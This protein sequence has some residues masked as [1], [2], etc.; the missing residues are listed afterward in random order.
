MKEQ[1]ITILLLLTVTNTIFAQNATNSSNRSNLEI[2][3]STGETVNDLFVLK[4][5]PSTDTIATKVLNAVNITFIGESAELFNFVQN[6]LYNQGSIKEIEPPRLAITN[7][8]G[9]F[10]VMGFVLDENGKKIEKLHSGYVDLH[11]GMFSKEYSH[12]ESITQLFP[13]EMG[14]VIQMY[15]CSDL[16][17]LEPESKS[18]NIH[19]FNITTNYNTAFSEGFAEHF[20]NIARKMEPSEKVKAGIYKDIESKRKDLPRYIKGFDR[21]FKLPLRVGFYRSITPLWYQQLENLKRYDLVENGNIKFVNATIPNLSLSNAIL[22]RNTGVEQNRTK[23]RNAAQAASTEGVISA[24]FTELVLSS[25]NERYLSVDFYNS[26]VTDSLTV[27]NLNQRI[28]PLQNE[29]MKIFRVMHCYVKT[30]SSTKGQLFDFVEGY[31]K[32]FPEEANQTME[33]LRN[34]TGISEIPKSL[35]EIWILHQNIDYKFWVMAQFGL[36]S[37]YYAFNLNTADS[38]DLITF[39]EISSYDA[40]KIIKHREQNG[41]FQS[42]N[43][44][45]NISNISEEA[46]VVLVNNLYDEKNVPADSGRPNFMSLLYLP[47]LHMAGILLIWFALILAVYLYLIREMELSYWNRVMKALKQLLKFLLLGLIALI[48]LA[49]SSLSW[50]LFIVLGLII[51]GIKAIILRKKRS[52]FRISLTITTLMIIVLLYSM[53]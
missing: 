1:L 12:L 51:V 43:E 44:I 7:R 33:I 17:S 32:E 47:L 19:Y 14:H 48:C 8:Q 5:V 52:E 34:T 49:L 23:L 24:F 20:E 15:L 42:I 27:D 36:T 26:F 16:N 37:P 41:F 18:P 35:P 39:K 53:I 13:H 6:Y 30:N 40:S 3:S 4:K 9:C 21:D 50:K 45:R 29:Y 10:G 38:L 25:L 11:K 28:N 22:Y 31:C 2:L 46:K